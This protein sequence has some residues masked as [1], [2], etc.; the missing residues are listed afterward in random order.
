[1]PLCQ[2]YEDNLNSG[3]SIYGV[4]QASEAV[5]MASFERQRTDN[6]VEL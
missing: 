5:L 1:M 4:P 2:W 6:R 3:G